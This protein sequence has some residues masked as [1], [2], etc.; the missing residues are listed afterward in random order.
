MTVDY[1]QLS[2]RERGSPDIVAEWRIMN[3]TFHMYN[4]IVSNSLLTSGSQM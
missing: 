2:V 3:W 1:R 4:V